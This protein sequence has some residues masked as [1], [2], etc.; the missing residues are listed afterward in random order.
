MFRQLTLILGFDFIILDSLRET[1]VWLESKRSVPISFTVSIRVLLLFSYVSA[2]DNLP[3]WKRLF[4]QHASW[5]NV[6]LCKNH[7]NR[8]EKSQT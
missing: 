7:D 1:T 2:F 8:Q 5:N 4:V 6:V 3:E